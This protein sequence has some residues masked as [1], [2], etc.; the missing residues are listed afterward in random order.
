MLVQ[1]RKAEVCCQAQDLVVHLRTR[2]FVFP[3]GSCT[4]LVDVV[5]E[6]VHRL[7]GGEA[8]DLNPNLVRLRLLLACGTRYSGAWRGGPGGFFRLASF[9]L[10]LH[11]RF[12]CRLIGAFASSIHP[13]LLRLGNGLCLG[14]L[15]DCLGVLVLSPFSRDGCWLGRGWRPG[16]RGR[17][18]A[19]RYGREQLLHF[20]ARSRR[21]FESTH[22]SLPQ[23]L[24][25]VWAACSQYHSMSFNLLFACEKHNIAAFL[26]VEQA[27]Q[28]IKHVGAC[29]GCSDI[30]IHRR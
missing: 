17:W 28:S 3:A 26:A 27:L 8:V 2:S 19:G 25:E 22:G 30:K 1:L 10:D 24:A 18:R 20:V 11:G 12:R 4:A 21:L 9:H 7:R 15:F 13:S 14:D 16:L 6:D 23:V 29:P 5:K